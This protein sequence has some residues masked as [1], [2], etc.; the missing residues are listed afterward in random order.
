VKVGDLVRVPG[1]PDEL[2]AT[3]VAIRETFD[4]FQERTVTVYDCLGLDG[5]GLTVYHPE[6]VVINESR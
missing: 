4:Y 2:L 5:Q 3:I 1:H 6:L